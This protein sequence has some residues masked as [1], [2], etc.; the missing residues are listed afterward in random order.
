MG[1]GHA[2][3]DDV[4]A[5][6]VDPQ[7]QVVVGGGRTGGPSV[8]TVSR[9]GGD[10]STTTA[11]PTQPTAPPN[12][13]G[14]TPTSAPATRAELGRALFFDTALSEPA[15]LAC[16]TCHQ[17]RAAFVDPRGGPTS[18][19]SLPG[20]AGARNTPSIL[21]ASLVPPLQQVGED[22]EGG[23]F[24]DGRVDTLEQQAAAPFTNPVE[25]ANPSVATVMAKVRRASYA[26]TFAALFGSSV[27]AD[28][29]AGF[30]AVTQALAAFE[31]ERQH[32]RFTSRYDAFLAGRGTL[33]AAE[34][35]GL[36]LFE[37]KARCS[38]CHPS[39]TDPVTGAAPMFT[40]FD[41]HNLGIPKNPA[42]PFYTLAPRF[43]PEGEDFVDHGLGAHV[44]DAE[45]GKFRTPTLRNVGRTAPYGH[46]GFFPTLRS[47]VDFYN[48]RDVA[49]WPL[50]E[51]EATMSRGIGD[52]GLT[53]AEID[54][55]VAFLLTLTDQ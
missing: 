25:M 38:G 47:I 14:A 35:R 39:A 22:F 6:D 2:A 15:G 18:Q 31:R 54:D 33:S 12:A 53:S 11:T 9:N 13:P 50:P 36:V 44:G 42:N 19:G 20:R 8:G 21:Y 26:G 23:L 45:D 28:D 5:R 55:V 46:N 52:I 24:L 43:N 4:A 10:G 16:G 40:R 48:S 37:G 7:A 29:Q 1:C 27:L 3:D 49:D 34:R 17:E 32:A 30:R 51:I 41:Y